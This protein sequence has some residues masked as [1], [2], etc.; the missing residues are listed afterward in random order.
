MSENY[1]EDE[2]KP[3]REAKLAKLLPA[4]PPGLRIN[5]IVA[6]DTNRAIGKNN[7]L[8]WKHK[9]D[10]KCFRKTTTGN[11]VV[12]GRKTFESMGYEPLPN[13]HNIV[14]TSSLHHTE[15]P[16]PPGEDISAGTTLTFCKTIEDVLSFSARLRGVLLS[17]HKPDPSVFIIG[18]ESLYKAFLPLTDVIYHNVLEFKVTGADAW[19]PEID[20][21]EWS[22]NHVIRRPETDENVAWR[23]QV[24][25]RRR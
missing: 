17:V 2:L 16:L 23:E 10:M 22:I 12:M 3:R 13:R 18:G 4:K 7:E 14:L 21:D 8:P 19:F 5:M 6:T 24:F 15:A 1:V 11:I 20:Q 25:V 9:G